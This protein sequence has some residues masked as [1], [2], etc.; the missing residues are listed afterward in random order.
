M[1]NDLDGC[2][3]TIVIAVVMVVTGFLAWGAGNKHGRCEERWKHAVTATDTVR[4]VRDDCTLPT[5]DPRA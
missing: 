2:F 5:G 4:L 1:Y 3:T